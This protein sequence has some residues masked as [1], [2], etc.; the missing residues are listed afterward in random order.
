MAVRHLETVCKK[1]VVESWYYSGIFVEEL[2]QTMKNLRHDTSSWCAAAIRAHHLQN[3]ATPPC[4][5]VSCEF[6]SK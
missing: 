1:A 5:L 2:R 6:A 4:S 3:T